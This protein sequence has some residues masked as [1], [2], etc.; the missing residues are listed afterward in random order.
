MISILTWVNNEGLY[1]KMVNSALQAN[2]TKKLQ[3]LPIREQN[4]PGIA[5]AYVSV[6]DKIEGNLIVL[7]HQ[8][9]EFLDKDF[10]NR[11]WGL[12]KAVEHDLGI[13]GI[14]GS[15]TDVQAPW[16]FN[17]EGI[18]SV[19]HNDNET[20]NHHVLTELF[21]VDGCFMAIK[22]KDLLL[23]ALRMSSGMRGIHYYDC[24]L[25]TIAK[26]KGLHNWFFPTKVKHSGFGSD[27]SGEFIGN[28]RIYVERF[29]NLR[30][31]K[32]LTDE[33]RAFLSTIRSAFV[34]DAEYVE[35]IVTP[36]HVENIVTIGIDLGYSAFLMDF[37]K[38]DAVKFH[39]DNFI[40]PEFA[41]NKKEYLSNLVKAKEQFG[42]LNHN[43][44]EVDS[45]VASNLL[46]FIYHDSK[47]Y[48][49]ID[50]LL[51][52]GDHSYEGVKSDFESWIDLV[53]EDGVIF[54]HDVHEAQFGVR[55][56]F[57][58]INYPRYRINTTHGLGVICKNS[59]RLY[60]LI[61]L[62]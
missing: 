24:V 8:D 10:F 56:Y 47:R 57:A 53:K 27:W 33:Q 3:F 5:E 52:D 39:I 21:M 7:C 48:G 28:Q 17:T 9:I 15:Q 38:L 62:L 45:Y 4:F 29:Y 54:M 40:D 13:I 46:P 42:K 35:H 2:L 26:R 59:K 31:F 61:K 12:F 37:L 16:Y 41:E 14:A 34:E 23:E 44:E 1:E 50:V 25:S 43:F 32:K 11:L 60:E 20:T 49:F 55:D 58:E 22:S 36:M 51:I 18:S 30:P 19:I 6:I